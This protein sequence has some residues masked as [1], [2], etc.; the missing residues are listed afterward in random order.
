MTWALPL[1]GGLA[2]VLVPWTKIE[3]RTGVGCEATIDKTFARDDGTQT[4]SNGDTD[5]P[6]SVSPGDGLG[7][8]DGSATD[9]TGGT[10]ADQ[11]TA[12]GT[13]AEM[14]SGLD[15]FCSCNGC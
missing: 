2:H 15:N 12:A 6:S 11:G 5:Q 3:S 13:D 4:A 7:A 9:A 14:V 8:G 1:P 10:T